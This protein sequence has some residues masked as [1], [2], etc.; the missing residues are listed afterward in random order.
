MASAL[1]VNRGNADTGFVMSQ[2]PA[3]AVTFRALVFPAPGRNNF[4]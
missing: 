2:P 1:D 3:L 4:T